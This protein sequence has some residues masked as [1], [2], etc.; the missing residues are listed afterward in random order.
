MKRN[1]KLL[2]NIL[3]CFHYSSNFKLEHWLHL[4]HVYMPV[5]TGISMGQRSGMIR[6]IYFPAWAGS[7]HQT[8]ECGVQVGVERERVGVGRKLCGSA[9]RCEFSQPN[10]ALS[11]SDCHL[12]LCSHHSY[13]PRLGY[14]ASVGAVQQIHTRAHW[15]HCLVLTLYRLLPDK[16]AGVKSSS[17]SQVSTSGTP[18]VGHARAC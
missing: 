10:P 2:I 1:T 7:K 8:R 14:A 4:I 9:A 3:C 17:H 18:H 13:L 11:D 5:Y 16:P 15:L 6:H 12:N